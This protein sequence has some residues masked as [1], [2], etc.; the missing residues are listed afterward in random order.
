M[1]GWELVCGDSLAL[2]DATANRFI[3]GIVE[4]LIANTMLL[5]DLSTNA[6]CWEMRVQGACARTG[7][8]IT[9]DDTLITK[10]VF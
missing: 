1:E 8:V 5:S 10:H 3:E 6:A 4:F 2:L 9:C 7:G